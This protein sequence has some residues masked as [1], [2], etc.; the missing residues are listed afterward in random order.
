MERE[1]DVLI[2]GSGPAGLQAAVHTARAKADVLHIEPEQGGRFMVSLESGV[3]IFSLALILAM[4]ISR[5]R[6][7]VPGEKELHVFT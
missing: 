7:N 4:G 6:L 1:F 5:N 2:P 3:S